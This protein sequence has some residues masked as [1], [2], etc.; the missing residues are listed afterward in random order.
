MSKA[1]LIREVLEKYGV[2][3]PADKIRKLLSEHNLIISGQDISNQ[4]RQYQQEPISIRS[5]QIA[6]SFK[7]QVDDPQHILKLI[8]DVGGTTNMRQALTIIDE[9]T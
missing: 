6:K 5:L 1:A 8:D 3:T 9:L 2:N 4:K 7:D